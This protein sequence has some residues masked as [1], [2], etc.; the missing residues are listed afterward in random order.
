[1][2]TAIACLLD[3]GGNLL[4]LIVKLHRVVKVPIR[5]RHFSQISFSLGPVDDNDG[6]D[7]SQDSEGHRDAHNEH[8]LLR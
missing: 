5:E 1:M 6:S 8:V 3:P 2:I 7:G 4:L